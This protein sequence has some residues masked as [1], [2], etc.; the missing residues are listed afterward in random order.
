MLALII[1]T[2]QSYK[3][4]AAIEDKAYEPTEE[5]IDESKSE[6]T[7]L[8]AEEGNEDRTEEVVPKALLIG[9]WQLTVIIPIL[10]E[11]RPKKLDTKSKRKESAYSEFV[12]IM[13]KMTDDMAQ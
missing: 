7:T 3:Y 11:V 9:H 1:Q 6:V 8:L 13:Q 5:D 10:S 12:V 4:L 2:L